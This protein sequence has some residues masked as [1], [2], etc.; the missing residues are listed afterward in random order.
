MAFFK[1]YLTKTGIGILGEVCNSADFG[2]I[3]RDGGHTLVP[4]PIKIPG[5]RC[6]R[7]IPRNYRGMFYIPGGDEGI[8]TLDTVAGILHFQCSALDQLCDVSGFFDYSAD[9]S[10]VSS[11]CDAVSASATN[12]FSNSASISRNNGSSVAPTSNESSPSAT[13]GASL[14]D[15]INS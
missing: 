4:L 1:C 9:I 5:F 7:N 8:R 13:D 12:E 2:R 6:K 14:Y 10:A 15:W 3:G 11:V